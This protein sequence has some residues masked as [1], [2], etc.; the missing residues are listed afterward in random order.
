MSNA[1]P[2]TVEVL[3]NLTYIA[4]IA[5]QS[6]S[7][8]VTPLRISM[9]VCKI[10]KLVVTMRKKIVNRNLGPGVGDQTHE[11]V[12][13]MAA[14]CKELAGQI[15][16]SFTVEGAGG[17]ASELRCLLRFREDAYSVW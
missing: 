10:Q 15:G 5:A 3:E 2:V 6:C 9:N 8:T 4:A 7:L 14:K 13:W 17:S 12:D 1:A 16:G 11:S